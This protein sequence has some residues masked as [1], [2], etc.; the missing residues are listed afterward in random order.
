[1]YLSSIIANV[2]NMYSCE[3]EFVE[4]DESFLLEC[5]LEEKRII[6]L[7]LS[8]NTKEKLRHI[9]KI[10]SC[11]TSMTIGYMDAFDKK[12][13]E[14]A[15]EAGCDIIFVRLSLIKNLGKTIEKLM[16]NA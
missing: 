16:S 14:Q 11:S 6:I 2:C 13:Q 8:N 5:D 12:L 7:N 1:M 3:L 4:G 10:R 9:Q 15:S